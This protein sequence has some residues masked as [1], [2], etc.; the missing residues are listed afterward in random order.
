MNR[1]TNASAK[2][3]VQ[4]TI[5]KAETVVAHLIFFT[6]KVHIE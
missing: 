3:Y 4:L 2:S 6:P 5:L 1:K